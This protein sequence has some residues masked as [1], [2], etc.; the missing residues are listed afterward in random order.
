MSSFRKH[1]N[2]TDSSDIESTET[3]LCADEV[4]QKRMNK[5]KKCKM[6]KRYNCQICQDF[7]DSKYN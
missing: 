7:E 1:Y 2:E 4:V 5:G 6:H 3:K